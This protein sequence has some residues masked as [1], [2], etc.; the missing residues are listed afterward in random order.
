MRRLNV[1]VRVFI[2]SVRRLNRRD[3]DRRCG[4]CDMRDRRDKNFVSRAVD[5]CIM[6]ASLGGPNRKYRLQVPTPLPIASLQLAQHE[7]SAGQGE[8]DGGEHRWPPTH[9]R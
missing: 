2:S 1:M 3:E 5:R 4:V 9:L 7:F 6:L 8:S